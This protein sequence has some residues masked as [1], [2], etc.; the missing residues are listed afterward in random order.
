MSIWS[1][2]ITTRRNKT[3]STDSDE[4]LLSLRRVWS[5]T[6]TIA[7]S[8]LGGFT[9]KEELE[10]GDSFT[11]TLASGNFDIRLLEINDKDDTAVFLV[12]RLS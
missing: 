1:Q 10:V 5:G 9:H 4:L 12:T 2:Q 3:V 7:V 11:Y 8:H 6:A